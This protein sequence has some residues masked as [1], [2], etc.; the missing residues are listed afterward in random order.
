M[1]E[2]KIKESMQHPYQVDPFDEPLVEEQSDRL[3]LNDTYFEA[4]RDA[5]TVDGMDYSF[6][7]PPYMNFDDQIRAKRKLI[8][9]YR[10]HEF[11]LLY[12]Y[13]GCGKSTLL[14]QFAE[15]YGPYARYFEDFKSLS[16]AQLIVQIGKS[17]N[18]P[19]KLRTSELIPL[20]DHL[21]T[22]PAMIL[23]F[24]EVNAANGVG[25]EK[26]EILRKLHC[27]TGIPI[28]IC[29]TPYLYKCIYDENKHD[30]F[31]SIITRLDEH[32]MKGMHRQDAGAYIRMVAST[33][34][35]KFTYPAEQALITTALNTHIGGINAFTTI[36]GRSITLARAMYYTAPGRTPPDNAK[37]I[38][39]E[40]PDET[41][42]PGAKLIITLPATPEPVLINEQLVS[43]M[44]AEYKAHFPQAPIPNYK[45]KTFS[46]EQR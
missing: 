38:R 34:N 25:Q 24:D 33:E 41:A 11:L 23:L 17:L 15:K 31:E 6:L 2:D 8:E 35:V 7:K 14:C 18:K 40:V 9:A 19:L 42:Y 29:G 43:Q 16:P 20:R 37:C 32:E 44:M 22:I 36:I 12:G 27:E 39:S 10:Q 4:A 46:N 21:K 30:L 13:S 26:L 28:V 1:A 45:K 3:I 5:V